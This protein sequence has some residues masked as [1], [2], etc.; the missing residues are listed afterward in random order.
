M[1]LQEL[2]SFGGLSFGFGM[3]IKKFRI[4]YGRSLYHPA[5]GTNHF[6]IITDL[7]EF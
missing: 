6:S 1:E 4:N 3:K 7:N 5:G 2:K